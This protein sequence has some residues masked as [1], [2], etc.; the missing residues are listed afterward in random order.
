MKWNILVGSMV[1]GASLCGQSFGGDLLHRLLGGHGCGA[2]SSCCDTTVAD[3]SC[4]AEIAAPCGN[5]C[6]QGPTC[7]AEIAAPACDPCAAAAGPSCGVESGCGPVCR[8]PVLDKLKGL[9]C[10]LHN[11]KANIGAHIKGKLA[12]LK[13]RGCD[14]G[15]GAGPSCGAEIAGC[16]AGPTCG[17]EIAAPCGNGPTCGAEIAACD[18]CA[19]PACDSGCG[20]KKRHA[21]LLSKIFKHK[22][23]CDSIACDAA[24]AGCSSCGSTTAAPAAP[25]AAPAPVVDPH[26]YMNTNRRVI[27]ASSTRVR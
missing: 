11:A 26:A 3:P 18:P 2:A 13:A 20:L 8:T 4:G 24:P 22:G 25:A 6:G 5:G 14:S 27:Q 7:G 17:A 1:L 9:K 19:A 23:G 15:C 10:K 21:G 16:G 12:A